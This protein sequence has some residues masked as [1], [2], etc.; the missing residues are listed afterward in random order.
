MPR[1]TSAVLLLLFQASLNLAG[2][3]PDKHSG[4]VLQAENI[5]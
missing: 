2:M 1:Q 5:F 3:T 4:V